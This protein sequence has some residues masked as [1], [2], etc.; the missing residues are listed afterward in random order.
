MI[1]PIHCV[2]VLTLMTAIL[3]GSAAWSP[4]GNQYE[5][6]AGSLCYCQPTSPLGTG[7]VSG[8]RDSDWQ[9]ALRGPTGLA[10]AE[11]EACPPPADD[12]APLVPH[13]E[14]QGEPTLAL[15]E[16]QSVDSQR[17]AEPVFVTVPV[18]GGL[19]PPEAA[20][21]PIVP[22]PDSQHRPTLAPPEPVSGGPMPQMIIVHV[23]A[24]LAAP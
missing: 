20:P 18:E 23:E 2:L 5:A 11:A 21:S 10:S 7:I 17:A 13:P 6:Q 15:S 4:H 12:R 1:K 8:L 19:S 9:A 3:W 24:E 14:N 22:I 16:L